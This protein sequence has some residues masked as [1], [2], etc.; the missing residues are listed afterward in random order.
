MPEKST[1]VWQQP[2]TVA[3]FLENVRDDVPLAIEQ[4]DVML[5][6]ISAA[7]E[8]ID[9]FLNIGCGDGVLAAAVLDE[10]P[11]SR[12]LLLD[13]APTP[14]ES[15][16]LRLR[17]H[18]G[19]VDCQRTDYSQAGWV[20]Q[21]SAHA[22]FD[23]IICGFATHDLPD[24]RKRD[25]YGEIFTLLK[26]GG[27]FLNLEHVASTTRWRESA[28]DDY[29]IDAIFGH[30]LQGSAGKSR[31]EVAREYYRSSSQEVTPLAPLEVQCDWLRE[32]GYESVDC[33]LKI[34]ELA[35]FGGQ[36]PE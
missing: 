29:L 3:K 1:P 27:A 7:R 16:R 20:Q 13:A 23:A 21:T 19:R 36:R 33:Y 8:Q 24:Q 17:P 11:H 9:S 26:P 30:Q 25:F 28:M 2:G 12:G 35:V 14:L 18:S 5:R 32:I 31:A 22:P 10:Y 4:I 15:A 34:S 6:L